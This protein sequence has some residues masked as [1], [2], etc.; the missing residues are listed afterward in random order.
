MNEEHNPAMSQP[1]DTQQSIPET[2]PPAPPDPLLEAIAEVNSRGFIL[3]GISQDGK[4]GKVNEPLTQFCAAISITD[5]RVNPFR[6]LK[7]YG[8]TPLDALRDAL[9]WIDTEHRSTPVPFI[10]ADVS[11]KHDPGYKAKR[12]TPDET[13]PVKSFTLADLGL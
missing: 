11:W 1:F 5:H 4:G 3:R 7:G 13:E 8:P 10:P 9:R 2:A 12:L 6:Y